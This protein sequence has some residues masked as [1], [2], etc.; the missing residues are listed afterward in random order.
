MW[1]KKPKAP[2]THQTP[3]GEFIQSNGGWEGY[4]EMPNE[5]IRITTDDVDGEPNPRLLHIIPLIQGKLSHFEAMAR[6]A[7]EPLSPQ[8]EFEPRYEFDSV[9]ISNVHPGTDF[10]LCFD[11]SVEGWSG[12]I[13]VEFKDEK[14]VCWWGM[15]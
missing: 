10:S 1:S 4:I 2:K 12:G 6:D 13:Y 3:F 15:D 11:C 5:D 8:S 9:D 14:I 7:V